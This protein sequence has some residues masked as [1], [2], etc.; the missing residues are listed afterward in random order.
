MLAAFGGPSDALDALDLLCCAGRSSLLITCT[1]IAGPLIA[2]HVHVA[3]AVFFHGGDVTA[4]A[5]A[6]RC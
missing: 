6:G 3:C 2:A 5:Y 1:Y 4:D